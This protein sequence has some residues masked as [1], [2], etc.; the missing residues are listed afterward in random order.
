MAFQTGDLPGAVVRAD[1]AVEDHPKH[2]V[3][4]NVR[5]VFL[6]Q[7]G[8]LEEAL[9][10]FATA[11]KLRPDYAEAHNNCGIALG[12][13]LRHDLAIEHY[14]RAIALNEEYAEA[15]N[16]LG[17]ALDALGQSE[18]ALERF[19]R[20]IELMP[21]YREAQRNRANLLREL[22]R[23]EAARAAFR[24]LWESDPD[25]VM[26]LFLLSMMH[27][28]ESRDDP[29]LGAMVALLDK[30]ETDLPQKARLQYGIARALHEIGDRDAAFTLW[31][32]AG[33]LR[34]AVNA[35]DPD[36][37][38][39]DFKALSATFTS[40]PEPTEVGVK[41]PIP[42]FILGMP[43]SG[44][45]LVEQMLAGHPDI[46]GAGELD[47]LELLI[48]RS[49]SERRV[50]TEAECAAIR[51]NFLDRLPQFAHGTRFVT[52][53]TP[54]NFQWIGHILTA[55][56]EA[57]II[58]LDRDPRA[59]CWSIFR[60]DFGEGG[61]GYPTVLRD[62]VAFQNHHAQVMRHWDKV[63]SDRVIRLDYQAL[64]ADPETEM[65]RVLKALGIDWHPNV[66]E[67]RGSDRAVRTLSYQQV[68]REIYSGSNEAWKAYASYLE[69]T[70]AALDMG[71][72]ET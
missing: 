45:S 4:H 22:G 27:K 17:T 70:F 18:Q 21:D 60:N 10:A 23:S 46:T 1:K 34:K 11:T 3:A 20:A 33:S 2:P 30:P 49:G 32:S 40:I 48:R 26:A 19:A 62:I 63:A 36:Q 15:Q 13:L 42:L 71:S 47:F 43:R 38:A 58:H 16:N 57:K 66:L 55:I 24:T 68:R 14:R 69:P 7:S 31:E 5:G 28:F 67:F 8:R 39:E 52:D 54:G 72:V 29:L 64:V 50:P 53:K 41:G 25:D 61:Q 37:V 59:V 44:T 6:M 9:E 65:K 12:D 51:E 56:P 35:Y